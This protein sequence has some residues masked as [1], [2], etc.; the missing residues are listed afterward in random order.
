MIHADKAK[1]LERAV[2][3]GTEDA[4]G[5]TDRTERHHDGRAADDIANLM[6][7]A[8][9]LHRVRASVPVDLNPHDESRGLHGVHRGRLHDDR[10]GL[11]EHG[12]GR[13]HEIGLIGDASG[14]QHADD[15][16]PLLPGPRPPHTEQANRH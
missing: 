7:I 1:S 5:T 10:C 2:E 12:I 15:D 8:D 13:E 16:G 9:E 14:R 6:V 4:A 11:Q 3:R